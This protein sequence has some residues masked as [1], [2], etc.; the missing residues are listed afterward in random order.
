MF[1]KKEALRYRYR[2]DNEVLK[3]IGEVKSEKDLD[4]L[5]SVI[6]VKYIGV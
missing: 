5:K 2:D 4:I 6:K 3:A 1:A